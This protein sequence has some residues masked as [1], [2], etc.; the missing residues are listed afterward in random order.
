MSGVENAF[1]RGSEDIASVFGVSKRTSTGVAQ[2][3]YGSHF[4]GKN[5][6]LSNSAL[7]APPTTDTAAQ[8][9]QQQQQLLARQKGVLA[10]IFSGNNAS[11]PTTSSSTALGA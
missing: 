7:G 6:Y 11:A 9:S 2:K 1:A 3:L 10:T 5:P 4:G 8:N